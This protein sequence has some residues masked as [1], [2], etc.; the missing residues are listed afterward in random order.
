MPGAGSHHAER[1]VHVGPD[2]SFP[3]GDHVRSNESLLAAVGT[4]DCA[5]S[6]IRRIPAA[7]AMVREVGQ[8]AGRQREVPSLYLG[9]LSAQRL[10]RA[11][12]ALR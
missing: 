3:Q 1:V 11:E 10:D 5:E 2:R 9:D 8:V 7:F 12:V 6:I 4:S